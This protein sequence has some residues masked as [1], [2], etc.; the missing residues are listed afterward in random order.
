MPNNVVVTCE[1]RSSSDLAW[2]LYQGETHEIVDE[3]SG[4]VLERPHFHWV[5]KRLVTIL[6]E[7]KGRAGEK[8][9][10]VEIPEW[11]AKKEG[12]I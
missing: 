12:L 7:W 11:L 2:A 6:K 8:M 1:L 9:I 4:E 10:E 5:A 3:R